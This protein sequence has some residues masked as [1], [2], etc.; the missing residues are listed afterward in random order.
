MH[1]KECHTRDRLIGDTEGQVG[2][3]C[4]PGKFGGVGCGGARTH[5]TYQVLYHSESSCSDTR[6]TDVCNDKSEVPASLRKARWLLASVARA[7]Q[8]KV[9][10]SRSR[11]LS[12]SHD[13]AVM[14]TLQTRASTSQLGPL[15]GQWAE[16]HN[17]KISKQEIFSPPHTGPPAKKRVLGRG[18]NMGGRSPSEDKTT[19]RTCAHQRG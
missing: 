3:A 6:L 17:I 16:V 7:R 9:V 4:R 8:R 5:H 10:S 19:P 18:G 1:A 12:A 13:C 14:P 15:A 11:C 2:W